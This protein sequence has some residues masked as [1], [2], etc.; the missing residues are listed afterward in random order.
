MKIKLTIALLFAF[1]L[2]QLYAQTNHAV[3]AHSKTRA[4]SANSIANGQKVYTQ[5]CLF[6]HHVDGCGVPNMNPP[7]S[8]TSYINGDKTRLIKVVLNGFMQPV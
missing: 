3:K 7:L 8:K 6:C 2:S 5:Y 4:V 1:G